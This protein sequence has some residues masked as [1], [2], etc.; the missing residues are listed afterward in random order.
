[1]SL[2][3]LRRQALESSDATGFDPRAVAD[4]DLLFGMNAVER[5]FVSI[6]LFL[7]VSILSFLL[8]LLSGSIE[9]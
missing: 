1:M 5:M 6:G 8:L 7:V 3:D 9:I 4:D 2:D